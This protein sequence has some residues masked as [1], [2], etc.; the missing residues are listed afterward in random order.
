MIWTELRSLTFFFVLSTQKN[1]IIALRRQMHL[2]QM[3]SYT[4]MDDQLQITFWSGVKIKLMLDKSDS[5]K[6]HVL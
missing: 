6:E 5:E 4:L 2:E 3:S 1:V